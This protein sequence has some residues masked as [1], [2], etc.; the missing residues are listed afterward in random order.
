MASVIRI[1]K[2]DECM[3]PSCAVD[4]N[5]GP[6]HFYISVE[7]AGEVAKQLLNV[8]AEIPTEEPEVVPGYTRTALKKAFDAVADPDDWKAPI[9]AT[10][11]Q[12]M[13]DVTAKAIWF[14]TGTSCRER[15]RW[16]DGRVAIEATGYRM[17]PAGDH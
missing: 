11:H 2:S 4:V 3:H 16:N 6:L 1:K 5:I 13:L 9:E 10:I 15:V 7:E 8:V 14:F 17:G 12:S